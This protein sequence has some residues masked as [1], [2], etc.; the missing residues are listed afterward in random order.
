MGFLRRLIDSATPEIRTKKGSEKGEGKKTKEFS[1]SQT[2]HQFGTPDCGFCGKQGKN[3]GSAIEEVGAEKSV[4]HEHNVDQGDDPYSV[5]WTP[6]TVFMCG[7]KPA[8][9]AENL[10]TSEE[11]K[12]V[13]RDLDH[14]GCRFQRKR[15][16]N[17]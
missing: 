14:R 2:V 9:K 1:G 13:M 12:K 8:V 4:L 3:T 5:E 17:T 6:T 16:K 15:R 10:H 7:G 11:I